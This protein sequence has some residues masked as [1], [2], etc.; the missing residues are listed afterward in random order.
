MLRYRWLH[1]PEES[2]PGLLLAI[3][4]GQC[5]GVLVERTA[6]GWRL[7]DGAGQAEDV[8]TLPLA[9]DDSP[10]RGTLRYRRCEPLSVGPDDAA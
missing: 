2:L 9:V 10:M 8:P 5:F 4:A 7:I 1:H 3:D 6:T